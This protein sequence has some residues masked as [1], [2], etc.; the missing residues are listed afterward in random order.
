MY[1]R[2]YLEDFWTDALTEAE[3]LAWLNAWLTEPPSDG[4]G[5]TYQV[6]P[7]TTL[8]QTVRPAATVYAWAVMP[9][10]YYLG[11]LP[12]RTPPTTTPPTIT[13]SLMSAA[14]DQR[15][16]ICTANGENLENTGQL[17]YAAQW[18][19][20]YKP[21]LPSQLKICYGQPSTFNSQTLDAKSMLGKIGI[22]ATSLPVTIS[23]RTVGLGRGASE[24]TPNLIFNLPTP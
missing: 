21:P 14:Q 18:K 9:A 24:Q 15:Y 13:W 10:V 23:I 6:E 11:T 5:R 3:Q 4:R 22:D 20:V 17:F 7:R 19:N 2:A 12:L 16:L 8:Q 1:C